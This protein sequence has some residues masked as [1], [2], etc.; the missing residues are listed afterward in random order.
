L[1]ELQIINEST[2]S[3]TKT[4]IYEASS[5]LSSKTSAHRYRPIRLTTVLVTWEK[6]RST[7]KIC[8]NDL[9]V[10]TT[11]PLGAKPI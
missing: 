1:A 4:F 7:C 9:Q 6:T 11:R 10:S 5:F 2:S 3:D 8:C